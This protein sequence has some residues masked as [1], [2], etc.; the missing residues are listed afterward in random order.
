MRTP[1]TMRP[2]AI[3]NTPWC[4][5][6]IVAHEPCAIEAKHHIGIRKG[7][8]DYELV[9]RTLHERRVNTHDGLFPRQAPSRSQARRHVPRQYPYQ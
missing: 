7:I 9:K 6:A 4:V 3:S 5:G 1:G 8:I 2:Y